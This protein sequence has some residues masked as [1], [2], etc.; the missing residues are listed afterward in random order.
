MKVQKKEKLPTV[1]QPIVRCGGIVIVCESDEDSLGGKIE[2][3]RRGTKK[4]KGFQSSPVWNPGSIATRKFDTK[5]HI[6]ISGMIRYSSF[7][8][9]NFL[10]LI[11]PKI[12]TKYLERGKGKFSQQ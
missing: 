7:S 4:K 9:V 3:L 8:V 11:A 5:V 12:Q 10:Q 2:T 1:L 6:C